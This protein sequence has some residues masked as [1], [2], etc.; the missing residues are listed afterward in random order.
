MIPEFVTRPDTKSYGQSFT[1][2]ERVKD[3]SID[4]PA[5][6]EIFQSMADNNTILDVTISM[7]NDTEGPFAEGDDEDGDGSPPWI[8]NPD[9]A[10][11][12]VRKVHQHGV[13]IVSGTDWSTPGEEHFPAVYSELEMLADETG[14]S[15]MDVLQAGTIHGAAALGLEE[16]LGTIETGKF[17]N[18]VFVEEDPLENIGNLRSIVLTVKRGTHYPR[19]EY[20][21]RGIPESGELN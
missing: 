12:L 9:I 17:A 15:N 6:S 7:L 8:C 21:H 10:R 16:E 19:A 4:D 5:V 14:M 20:E 11:S 13:R 2:S 1:P 18:L 3:F